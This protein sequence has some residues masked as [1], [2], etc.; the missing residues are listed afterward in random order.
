MIKGKELEEQGLNMFYNVGKAAESEP[1]L[2]TVHYKGNPESDTT[3]F[4]IVGKGLTYDTGGLD[5]KPY[6]HM[7][8]MHL[9]KGGAVATLGALKGAIELQLPI[10]VAFVFGIA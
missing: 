1:R 2:M 6:P 5:L 3:D 9:D 7:K 10:N 4:A 8:T